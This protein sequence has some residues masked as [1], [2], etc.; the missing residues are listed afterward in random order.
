MSAPPSSRNAEPGQ[1]V[2]RAVFELM[3]PQVS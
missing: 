1:Y 2:V 3:L